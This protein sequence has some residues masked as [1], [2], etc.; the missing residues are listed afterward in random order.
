MNSSIKSHIEIFG[1]GSPVVFVHG[2]GSTLSAWSGIVEK[3]QGDYQ[4]ICYD[5]R[6]HGKSPTPSLPYELNDLVAD[7]RELF[8]EL[9]LEGA[10]IVGHSLGGMIGPGFAYAYPERVTSISMFSTA[11]G[12]TNE[13][14]QK[15]LGLADMIETSGVKSTLKLFTDR[16]FTPEFAAKNPEIVQARMTQLLSTDERVFASVF[17]IYASTEMKDILPNIKAPALV[18][19]GADD[20]GCNPRINRFMAATL[21]NAVLEILPNLRHSI[22]LEAPDLVATKLKRFLASV[23]TA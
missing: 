6:G 10:H 8:N 22:L 7:L 3:L 17:R 15:V 13:E 21:P 18:L 5:L 12:R 4:C 1:D 23:D 2:V 19:T 16:W 14:S 11:A 20:G 9:D